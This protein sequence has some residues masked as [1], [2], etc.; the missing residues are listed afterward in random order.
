MSAPTEPLFPFPVS[1]V[2]D[3]KRSTVQS[4]ATQVSSKQRVVSDWYESNI[5]N[6]SQNKISKEV[7]KLDLS[8][9]DVK[10][11][12][13][14]KRKTTTRLLAIVAV[15]LVILIIIIGITVG[16]TQDDG[17]D[18]GLI[19]GVL[20]LEDVFAACEQLER[21]GALDNEDL[22]IVCISS[23]EGGV[24]QSGGPSSL[25]CGN[26]C[27]CEPGQSV[28]VESIREVCTG[29]RDPLCESFPFPV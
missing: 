2:L 11:P 6:E 9:V 25:T 29:E 3:D 8:S 22:F 21:S 23:N 12:A 28:F 15:V 26:E 5:V 7:K 20:D 10:N 13:Q 16:L 14:E 17:Y 24:C 18:G 1:R 27:N 19:P 4:F